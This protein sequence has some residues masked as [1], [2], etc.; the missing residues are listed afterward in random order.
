MNF[1]QVRTAVIDA[2]RTMQAVDLM[3][4]DMTH[5]IKGRLRAMPDNY[6]NRQTLATLKREL[7]QFNAKTMQWKN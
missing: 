4:E 7:S 1:V 2:R 3:T 5:L 6:R